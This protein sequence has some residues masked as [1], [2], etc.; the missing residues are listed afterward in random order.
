MLQDA[1]P[2]LFIRRYL[3]TNVTGVPSLDGPI[4]ETCAGCRDEHQRLN[5]AAQHENV[6]QRDTSGCDGQS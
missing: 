1:P 4:P 5:T 3:R 2:F 6:A